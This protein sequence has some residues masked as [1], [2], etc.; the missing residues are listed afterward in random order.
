MYKNYNIFVTWRPMPLKNLCGKSPQN[1]DM[2]RKKV[3]KAVT[4]WMSASSA[5]SLQPDLTSEKQKIL[6][7]QF[8]LIIYFMRREQTSQPSCHD[9]TSQDVSCPELGVT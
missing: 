1:C 3:R 8:I 6:L 5:L 4:D 9:G 2:Q 7:I